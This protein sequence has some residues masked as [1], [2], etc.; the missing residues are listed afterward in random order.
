MGMCSKEEVRE[1][2]KKCEERIMALVHEEIR[3][4]R[5]QA[6][7]AIIDRNSVHMLLEQ[8]KKDNET[9][10]TLAREILAQATKTNGRVNGL[11][12]WRATHSVESDHLASAV[13]SIK[14][15]V[16]SVVTVVLLAVIGAVLSLVLI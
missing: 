3:V 14:T 4:L 9:T 6:Q 7:V 13:A 2:L 1:E 11:E 12:T 10:H 8:M 15:G 5:E 16:W